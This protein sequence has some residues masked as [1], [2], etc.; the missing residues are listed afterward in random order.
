MTKQCA[1][2]HEKKDSKCP[3]CSKNVNLD[4]FH[5]L[6]PEAKPS[7]KTAEQFKLAFPWSKP[8]LSVLG[9]MNPK[10]KALLLKSLQNAAV[11][12]LA[13]GLPSALIAGINADKG[14][15]ASSALTAGL[16]M[17][18]L[19]AGAHVG[20]NM[21]MGTKSPLSKAY[22]PMGSK[23]NDLASAAGLDRFKIAYV[24][25]YG[26]P[27]PP[28]AAYYGQY[29]Q[30]PN[31]KGLSAFDKALLLGGGTALA[32]GL[33]HTLMNTRGNIRGTGLVN[34][35]QKG[36]GGSIRGGAN[37]LREMAGMEQV[38]QPDHPLLGHAKDLASGAVEGAKG[39]Y[40]AGK[41]MAP[42]A[43]GLAGAGLTANAFHEK[44]M[45]EQTRGGEIY[46]NTVGPTIAGAKEKVVGAGERAMDWVADKTAPKIKGPQ[47]ARSTRDFERI[48][49]VRG[50]AKS[51]A[52][53]EEAK[54]RAQPKVNRAED[55]Q[56]YRRDPSTPQKPMKP[57]TPPPE[58]P[59]M[60]VRRAPKQASLIYQ[61]GADAALATYMR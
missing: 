48:M 12:A 15:T 58:G 44:M 29:G 56:V 16:G 47:G 27:L 11:P 52:T 14:D 6:N 13:V 9:G 22:K 17:G 40:G 59:M 28:E 51:T 4:S 18:G 37:Q 49:G 55:Q 50:G 45:K 7:G 23:I 43:M 38:A 8:P 20:H 25:A 19:A 10:T 61:A 1:C 60:T 53:P 32:G 2:K 30:D 5:R 41:A 33:H 57:K 3:A 21:L 35:Y 26:R 34:A 36:I 54:A 46:R 42:A 31:D 39:L 24:D